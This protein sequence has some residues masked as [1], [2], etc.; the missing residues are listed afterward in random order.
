V[1]ISGLKLVKEDEMVMEGD[2]KLRLQKLVFWQGE[3]EGRWKACNSC[4]YTGRPNKQ[5]RPNPH[6]ALHAPGFHMHFFFLSFTDASPSRRFLYY[7]TVRTLIQLGLPSSSRP[8]HARTKVSKR[9][10]AL[11]R[12]HSTL[13]KHSLFLDS[14]N[15]RS[16]YH[17]F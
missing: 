1:L 5:E 8:V 11:R 16:V 4:C 6:F 13:S 17:G 12:A 3:G 15:L 2:G 9:T 14:D 10:K 7:A